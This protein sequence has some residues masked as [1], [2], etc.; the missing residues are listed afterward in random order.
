[1][2]ASSA[3]L[4]SGETVT[5]NAGQI[6]SG[7][8]QLGQPRSAPRRVRNA[9]SQQEGRLLSGT[10]SI[11][12]LA[13]AI[14]L[15]AR[16][17]PA[18]AQSIS[19]LGVSIVVFVL[20]SAAGL[21]SAIAWGRASVARAAQPADVLHLIATLDACPEGIA[22][23]DRYGHLIRANANYTEFLDLASV[24]L[25]LGAPREMITTIHG[26]SITRILDRDSNLI[27]SK[28]GTFVLKRQDLSNGDTIELLSDISI[29]KD[30]EKALGEHESQL[31]AAIKEMSGLR[32]QSEIQTQD[33]AILQD[34]IIIEKQ[35]ADE[36]S[37]GKS[38]FLSHMSHELRTPLNAILGFSDMMRSEIFGPIGHAKYSEYADDIHTSGNDLLSLI[39]DILDV[40]QI[41]AG[42]VPIDRQ[43]I[44]MEKTIVDCL[45][46][47]RPRIYASGISLIENIDR[48][49]TVH[50]D[51]MAIRQI[52]LHILS[53]AMKYTPKGGRISIK[54]EIDLE[55]V[56][57][58]IDDT[59]VG[60]SPE[61]M[62][63]LNEPFSMTDQDAHISGEDGSGRS[64]GLGVGIPVSKSLAR[65]NGG[66]IDIQSE[67]G[68]G[69]TVRIQIPR[70]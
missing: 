34:N 12:L 33:I 38:E 64:S 56:T 42:D 14:S 55:F 13:V 47:L 10:L 45:T 20:G 7:Q 52:I 69:T 21:V 26:K 23:W 40:T 6:Q 58:I 1:M 70:R 30:R 2:A 4:K 3:V 57:L 44:D 36:A 46:M 17:A 19:L 37:R 67:K 43:R 22:V 65:L 59:G 50:A 35:R 48:L 66:T 16:T 24:D 49:P 60:I 29:L 51:P 5:G 11:A 53:N 62:E 31:R 8:T 68:F 41:Q 39:A 32:E 9:L 61:I 28:R 54:A 15:I 18:E 63:R 25:L 27:E